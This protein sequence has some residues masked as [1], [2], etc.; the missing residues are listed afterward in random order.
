[1]MMA[2]MV[3]VCEAQVA[4][5]EVSD[6]RYPEYD[7][8]G[9]LKHQITGEKARIMP[10]GLVEITGLKVELFDKK[11]KVNA[12]A[13]SPQCTFDRQGGRAGASA[14]LR[15]D[16]ESMVLTGENYYWDQAKKRIQIFK[17]V[18]V[19]LKNAAGNITTDGKIKLEEAGK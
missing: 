4:P 12:Q 13:T 9:K 10:N 3:Y 8:E 1:M 6:F 15:I 18:H 11:G 14:P 7:E 19:T 16:H 2:G 5:Q 17:K